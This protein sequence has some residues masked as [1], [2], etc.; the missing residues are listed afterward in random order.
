MSCLALHQCLSLTCSY[1]AS[2]RR[3]AMPC[4][5]G[6]RIRHQP[7]LPPIIASLSE[8]PDGQSTCLRG[9]PMS[10]STSFRRVVIIVSSFFAFVPF[11]HVA[12]AAT[13]RVRWLPSPDSTVTGY[14]VYVRDAGAPHADDAAWSGNP[15]REAN[16]TMSALVTFTP[17][18]A[19]A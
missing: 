7:L 12:D 1:D 13:A 4:E 6:F 14:E 11:P 19:G 3:L 16:G 9:P 17:S 18:A 8:S 2:C 15:A 5:A 10:F